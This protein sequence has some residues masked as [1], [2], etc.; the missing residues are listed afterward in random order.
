MGVA[1]SAPLA[2][3]MREPTSSPRSE[4]PSAGRPGYHLGA[5]GIT[6]FGGAFGPEYAPNPLSAPGAFR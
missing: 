4:G 2:L 6:G 1:C 3:A 5:G